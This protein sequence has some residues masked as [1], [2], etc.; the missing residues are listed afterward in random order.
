MAVPQCHTGWPPQSADITMAVSRNEGRAMQGCTVSPDSGRVAFQVGGVC[1]ENPSFILNAGLGV[2]LWSKRPQ[3]G[4][5]A[6]SLQQSSVTVG[7]PAWPFCMEGSV[8]MEG[9]VSILCRPRS[10]QRWAESHQAG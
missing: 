2:P 6:A 8:R 10:A 3:E 9:Q 5:S 7:M 1:Q 4:L